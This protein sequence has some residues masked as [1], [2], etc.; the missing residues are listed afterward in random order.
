MDYKFKSAAILYKD[1]NGEEKII[2]GRRHHEIIK[3]IHD[4]GHTDNYKKYHVDGFIV[5][6]KGREYFKDRNQSTDIAKLLG[7]KMRASVLTSE[8]LW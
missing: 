8:D 5:E 6:H 7:I 3:N 1:P 4:L 2:T